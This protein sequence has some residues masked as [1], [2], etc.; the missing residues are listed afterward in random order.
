ML[1]TPRYSGVTSRIESSQGTT[2]VANPQG[3]SIS[4]GISPTEG[5]WTTVIASTAYDSYGLL[6]NLNNGFTDSVSVTSY[7][8]IGVGAAGSETEIVS[9]IFSVSAGS[10]L[11]TE[12][13]WFYFPVFVKAGTRISVRGRAN[14]AAKTIRAYVQLKQFAQ[15]SSPICTKVQYLTGNAVTAGTT[16]KGSWTSLGVAA[17]LANFGFVFFSAALTATTLNNLSYH[18]DFAI[19]DGTNFSIIQQDVLLTSNSAENITFT[20]LM[21][22][23]NV[24]VKTGVTFYGRAQCSGTPQAFAMALIGGY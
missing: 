17:G 15:K 19:G 23:V 24:P 21:D 2:R 7:I 8:D 1:F 12:G 14:A 22:L 4:L 20:G 6:L 5:S 9:D 13:Q 10:Y 11:T 3:T 18:C 16:S